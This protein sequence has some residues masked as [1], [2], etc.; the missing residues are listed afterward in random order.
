[1]GS[2]QAIGRKQLE[3]TCSQRAVGLEG[4]RQEPNEIDLR[5]QARNVSPARR[6][7][8]RRADGQRQHQILVVTNFAVESKG[9]LRLYNLERTCNEVLRGATSSYTT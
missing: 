8:V 7:S 3:A 5:T 2:G 9:L 6:A 4:A 1:M